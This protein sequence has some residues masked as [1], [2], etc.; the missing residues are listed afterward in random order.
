MK[1]AS[2]GKSVGLTEDENPYLYPSIKR[3]TEEQKKMVMIQTF[4]GTAVS[5]LT[6][7][8]V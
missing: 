6:L 3:Q 7:I 2:L 4:D 8:V 5:R 1:L